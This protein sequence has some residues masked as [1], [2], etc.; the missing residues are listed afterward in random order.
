MGSTPISRYRKLCLSLPG[1]TH[2]VKFS[3]VDA[4]SV[5]GRLYALFGETSFSFKVD[6]ERFLELTDLEGVVPAKFMAGHKW[7]AVEDP[8]ALP[9]A[10]IEALLVRAHELIARK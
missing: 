1:T 5:D 9:V 7:V 10:E 6:P 8:K 3:G 2:A 4:Y